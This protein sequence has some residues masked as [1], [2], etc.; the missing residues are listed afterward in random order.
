[1]PSSRHGPQ[2]RADRPMRGILLIIAS[3]I[4]NAT[5]DVMA[6]FLT[7]SLPVVEIAWIRF[8]C[9]A[10]IAVGMVLFTMGRNGLKASRPG[11]QVLRGVSIVVSSVFFIASLSFIPVAEATA[12]AFIAPIFVTALSIPFLG[13]VVGRRRWTAAFVGLIGVLIVVRPGTAAFHPGALLTILSALCWACTLVVTRKMSGR[14]HATTTLVWSALVGFGLLSL[15]IPFYWVPPGPFE[16]LIGILIG[17][18]ATAGQWL[19]ILGF[20]FADASVLAPFSYAQLIWVTGLGYVIFG[21]IPD[22]WTFVGAAIIIAS[23]LYTANRER[24]RRAQARA[25]GP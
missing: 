25:D 5:S 12:T 2:A 22:Q 13:E 21:A 3:T 6:K 4:C 8:L 23:G 1:M 9:F 16:L 17:V 11:L 20:R 24:I 18:V 14:D 19:V 7:T 15:A 10:V